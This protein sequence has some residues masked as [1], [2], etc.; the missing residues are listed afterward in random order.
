M[1]GR[2]KKKK[3][4]RGRWSEVESPPT[5][6]YLGTSTLWQGELVIVRGNNTLSARFNCWTMLAISRH[7]SMFRAGYRGVIT[8]NCWLWC[9]LTKPVISTAK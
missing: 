8:Y 6:S 2:E 3:R 5:S 9:Y 4:S 7:Y 1:K